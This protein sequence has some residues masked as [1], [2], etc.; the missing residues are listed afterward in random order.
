MEKFSNKYKT[1]ELFVNGNFEIKKRNINQNTTG[2]IRIR[3]TRS[4]VDCADGR[5]AVQRRIDQSKYN[6]RVDVIPDKLIMDSEVFVNLF[7]ES[8]EKLIGFVRDLFEEDEVNGINIV[9]L[10]GGFSSCSLI[11]DAVREAFTNKRIIVPTDASL[12]ILKG[13]VLYGRQTL[14]LNSQGGKDSAVISARRLRHTY[15]ISTLVPFDAQIHSMAYMR[16]SPQGL[17]QCDNIFHVFFKAGQRVV[18]GQTSETCA[19][20]P[21]ANCIEVYRTR[22]RDPRYVL[23]EGVVLHY[24]FNDTRP[25]LFDCFSTSTLIF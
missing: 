21:T 11:V 19:F 12:A 25:C 6:G 2:D 4:L 9:L 14:S 10:V 17:P 8:K 18:P 16:L 22:S 1:D 13:A 3:I 24:V 5:Q 20:N 15:G 23:D 7:S